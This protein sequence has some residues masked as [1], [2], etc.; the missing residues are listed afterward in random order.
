MGGIGRP[1]WKR[2]AG[3][4]FG[5]D[6][7]SIFLMTEAVAAR[8]RCRRLLFRWNVGSGG[9]EASAVVAGWKAAAVVASIAAAA[10]AVW[11]FGCSGPH[12]TG[13]RAVGG[14]NAAAVSN[15]ADASVAPS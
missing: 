6:D 4:L 11:I 3:T 14:I 12:C 7:G 15:A 9:S 8:R 5:A 2:I 10:V 13:C 1:G